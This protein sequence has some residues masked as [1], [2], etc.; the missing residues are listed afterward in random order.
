MPYTYDPITRDFAVTAPDGTLLGVEKTIAQAEHRDR[1]ARTFFRPVRELHT[2][3]SY[4]TLKLAQRNGHAL[5]LLA[6]MPTHVL[7]AQ[8][9]RYARECTSD[10]TAE[11]L[12]SRWRRALAGLAARAA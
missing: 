7:E 1:I 11:Q 5:A 9:V 3:L 8:A 2:T 12:L 4:Q 10:V 6:A